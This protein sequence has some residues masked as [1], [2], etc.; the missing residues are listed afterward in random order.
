[1]NNSLPILYTFRRCPYAMRARA[2]LI[3][4]KIQCEVRE[5]LL[6]DKPQ[7]MLKISPKGTVPVLLLPNGN[8]LEESLDIMRWAMKE[9]KES[10]EEAENLILKTNTDFKK[11]LDRYKYSSHEPIEARHTYRNLAVTFLN[12][13][14]KRLETSPFL[15]GSEI[16]FADI[17]ILPFVRQFSLIEPDWFVS[18]GLPKI[19]S[20]LKSWYDNQSFSAVMKKYPLWVEGQSSK[21]LLF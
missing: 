4:S 1:M 19:N 15:F 2:A 8:V 14:E 10:P 20:W 12:E 16:S 13:L 6:S 11:N 17:A 5:I 9:N 21:I 3:S 18:C 7:Q